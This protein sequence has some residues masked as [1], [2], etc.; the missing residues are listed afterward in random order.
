MAVDEGN[1]PYRHPL[2]GY[3]ERMPGLT[4]ATG[5][6]DE[7]LGLGVAQQPL[8]LPDGHQLLRHRVHHVRREPGRHR[9]DRIHRASHPTPER[10]HGGGRNHHGEDGP[11]VR[12]LWD[13][14]P[15]PK[16]CIA[17]GSCAISGDFYRDIYSVVPG[18]DTIVP[19]DV[20]IPGCPP[21]PDQVIAGLK[22]LQ[23]KVKAR[24]AGKTTICE[25]RP[26]N[27]GMIRP[28]IG[29]FETAERDDEVSEAQLHSARNQGLGGNARRTSD[30]GKNRQGGVFPSTPHEG[31]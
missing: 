16:W 30:T 7:A 31:D 27:S 3:M 19:V 14:M 23:D 28:D 21:N 24:R 29:R 20:Y 26:E 22:R 6:I 11:R 12:K 25:T 13:Q 2:Y 1:L 17:M 4:L 10:R 15:E 8:D 18:V 9:S 5:S